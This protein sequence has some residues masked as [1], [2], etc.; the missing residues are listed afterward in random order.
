MKQ[1]LYS[2]TN[3]IYY[4][5]HIKTLSSTVG[6]E[7]TLTPAIVYFLQSKTGCQNRMRKKKSYVTI[8][9]PELLSNREIL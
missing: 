2:N 1:W 3:F 5:E 9:I 4:I 7:V 8:Q 6:V